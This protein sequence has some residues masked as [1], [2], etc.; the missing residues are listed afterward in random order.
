M[1][2]NRSV[3]RRMYS[4][5]Q[6]AVHLKNGLISNVRQSDLRQNVCLDH[7]RQDLGCLTS[8]GSRQRLMY[9]NTQH[10]FHIS[11]KLNRFGLEFGLHRLSEKV[12]NNIVGIGVR[13]RLHAGAQFVDLLQP[14]IVAVG[15]RH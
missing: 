9:S 8:R 11:P 10:F 13:Q 14:Y 4:A 1:Y 6:I 15:T 3:K 7:R 12:F 2:I 5:L